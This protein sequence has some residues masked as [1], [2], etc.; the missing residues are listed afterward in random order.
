MA[1]EAASVLGRALLD[2]EGLRALLAIV[3]EGNFTGAAARLGLSQPAVSQQVRRLEA[4]LGRPL[5]Q[6]T[7]KRVALTADGEAMLGYARAMLDLAAR[8]EAQFA[9][10]A[11]E[12]TVRFGLVEDFAL[13]GLASVLAALRRV[14]PRLYIKTEVGM[15]DDLFRAFDS[16]QLDLVL[17]K[18]PLG[19]RRGELLWTEDLV[20]V[21]QPDLLAE[22][23]D[24]PVPLALYPAR[25]ASRAAVIQALQA[26]GR[27]WTVLFE[28]ASIAS[29][30]AAVHAGVGLSAFGRNLLPDGM[31]ALDATG[32]LPEPGRV[33]YVVEQDEA[34]PVAATIA[35]IIHRAALA[36]VARQGD[37]R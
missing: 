21:G 32:V 36:I 2:G 29:V 27:T 25:T 26:A 16:G 12:G 5:F 23:A 28:S 4:K 24:G 34:H 22:V 30:R 11:L 9:G 17:A 8:A 15:C 19:S 14:H 10:D 6:R 13:I 18:R 31:A 33:E 35:G 3:E 7:T 37:V 20:W 1:T